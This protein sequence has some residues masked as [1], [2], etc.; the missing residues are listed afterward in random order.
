M[1]RCP[2]CLVIDVDDID[3][4]DDVVDVDDVDV[5]EDSR[6]RSTSMSSMRSYFVG[7]CP[8]LPCD[9][10]RR[11]RPMST[12]SIDVDDVD[13]IDD[14]VDVDDGD[15]VEDSPSLTSTSMSSM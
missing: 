3:D 11:C 5:V 9:R 12:M 8:P 2:P 15:V 14:V 4:V 7:R 13:D 6:L 10:R 1:G